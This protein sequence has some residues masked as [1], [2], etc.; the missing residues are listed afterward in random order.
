MILSFCAADQIDPP[1]STPGLQR[2]RATRTVFACSEERTQVGTERKA[3]R[4]G[5]RRWNEHEAEPYQRPEPSLEEQSIVTVLNSS[6]LVHM[7]LSA[8]PGS[9]VFPSDVKSQPIEPGAAEN[10]GDLRTQMLDANGGATAMPPGLL[11]GH[12][13]EAITFVESCRHGVA[14]R[15]TSALRRERQQ[16]PPPLRPIPSEEPTFKNTYVRHV[17]VCQSLPSIR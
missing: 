12:F 1:R 15:A 5:E 3:N 4:E 14:S 8:S 9:R 7:M 16:L 2:S 13:R 11:G 17:A 10:A 6:T